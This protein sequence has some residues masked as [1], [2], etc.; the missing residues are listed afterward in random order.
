MVQWSAAGL[1]VIG[2]A[3]AIGY[4]T[5][6]GGTVTQATSK[7]TGVTLNKGTG[8]IT[9]AADALAA[10]ATATFTFTNSLIAAADQVLVQRQS[11]GTAGAYEVWCDSSAA[12][13]CT[14]CI[15]NRTAGSLSEAVVLNFALVKGA[16]A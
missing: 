16:T 5:G 11:G 3:A 1:T 7:A 6:S 4:A 8:Q 14:I 15:R 10:G 12:G 2:A 9:T 13:S